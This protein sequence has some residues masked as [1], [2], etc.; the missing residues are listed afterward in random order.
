LNDLGAI[1]QWKLVSVGR[2]RIVAAAGDRHGHCEG[3][4]GAA[5]NRPPEQSI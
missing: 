1:D 2:L 3:G 4:K 5:D